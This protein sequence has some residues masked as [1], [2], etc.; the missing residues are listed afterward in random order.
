MQKTAVWLLCVFG[1]P[2]FAENYLIQGEQ[3]STIQYMLTQ[4]VEPAGKTQY[5]KFSFVIPADYQ[6]PTYSQEITDFNMRFNPPPASQKN[7]TDN[8]GNAV[9]LAEW[10]NLSHPVEAVM[11]F[12]ART[13]NV[14]SQIKLSAPFP[15]GSV[16]GDIRD[17][18][19]PTRQ[20]QSDDAGIQSRAV[21]I[22]SGVTTQ[23][24]AVQRILT[25]VVDHMRYVTPPEQYDAAYS[26]RTGKG[27]CQNYSHLAA[28]LMRHVGIPVRIV[29]GV[30]LKEPYTIRTGDGEF[31]FKMGQGR[32]SW[33]EIWFPD[34]GWVP[35]E[36]QQTAL[37]VS[38]RFVRCE[39]GVDNNETVNDGM[40]KYRQE[41]GV[42]GTPRFQEVIDARF[43]SDHVRLAMEKQNYGP[44]N[45]LL[46]PAVLASFTPVRVEPPPPP[47]RV[48]EEQ[49]RR[50]QYTE[51]F[52]FG[53]LDFPLGVNFIDTRSPA[54]QSAQDEFEMHKN[55][56]VETAEYVTTQ[57]TQY[58][59]V[60]VLRK[61]VQL[62]YISLALHKFGGDGQ[63][64]IDLMADD[65]GRPGRVIGTSDFMTLS[66]I[67]QK[68]GYDWV[69][70]DFNRS[71]LTLPP[72][73]YWIG[74]G[75]TGS[76]IMNWFYTYGKPVGPPDGTRY[77]GV[78][79]EDWSGALSYEFNYRVLGFAAQ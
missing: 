24:D 42:S 15:V 1:M 48:T 41:K 77:K 56:L 63:V 49:L 45:M 5:L 75:F 39:I 19:R 28:A 43:L 73:S 30:T 17:F 9:I 71:D 32:H 8:R 14:L 16:P 18:L 11:T 51:R 35:F 27:N 66:Q 44:R 26:F 10:N 2:G 52:I 72:G 61:P 25:W 70:F 60:F 69:N 57:A 34:V 38:N 54:Q 46:V 22:V 13:R 79:D 74:F 4:R 3:A 21:Q 20:V 67:P 53:N 31:T 68:Q 6:S 76:P 40:V 65:D 29:N 47:P 33:V 37:F 64:W 23:F 7:T 62:K 59:Q 58:A 36:P 12:T 55:F 78:Y 50:F